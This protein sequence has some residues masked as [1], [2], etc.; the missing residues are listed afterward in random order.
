MSFQQLAISKFSQPSVSKSEAKYEA[1]D[2][3]MVF[4]HANKTH[5]NKKGF[6]LSLVLKAR[7]FFGTQKWRNSKVMV[8]FCQMRLY[9]GIEIV[10]CRLL[11][12]M[13]RIDT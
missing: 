4:P 11:L 6:A 3:E 7:V 2:M 13:A 9:L 1:I 5:F 10:S 8:Q 12:R